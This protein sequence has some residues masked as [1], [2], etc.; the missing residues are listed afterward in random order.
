MHAR[1][2][3]PSSIDRKW[4]SM[5]PSRRRR[6]ISAQDV[7]KWRRLSHLPP[8]Q[9]VRAHRLR[10]DAPPVLRPDQRAVGLAHA[11]DAVP[12]GDHAH[13]EDRVLAGVE[14]AGLEVDRPVGHRVPGRRSEEEAHGQRNLDWIV[15]GG[16]L[17]PAPDG[18]E[19]ILQAGS[20]EAERAE[21]GTSLRGA[22]PFRAMRS[23]RRSRSPWMNWKAPGMAAW[24][25]SPSRPAS[26]AAASR[27]ERAARPAPHLDGV[28]AG[29]EHDG[30]EP[31]ETQVDPGQRAGEPE[32]QGL[33]RLELQ[34]VPRQEAEEVRVGHRP[35]QLVLERRE[36]ERP[37]Q[38][39]GGRSRGRRRA[40]AGP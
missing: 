4:T 11:D 12:D 22:S 5:T 21:K 9:L 36:V 29:Q 38:P 35:G 28:A 32:Q 10:V 16:G 25:S 14:P 6:S 23:W 31:L 15:V 17:L 30:E 33:R 3:K 20:L 1:L 2:R 18:A 13:R 19:G 27:A 7:R 24:A 40:A 37:A 8:H 26:R 39:A 34:R